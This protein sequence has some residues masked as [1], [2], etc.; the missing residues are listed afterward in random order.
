[1]M[2]NYLNLLA[3]PPLQLYSHLHNTQMAV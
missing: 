2:F 3:K 1:M